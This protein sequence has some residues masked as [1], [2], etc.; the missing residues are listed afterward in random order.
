MSYDHLD[1]PILIIPL[2]RCLHIYIKCLQKLQKEHCNSNKEANAKT[3]DASIPNVTT[4][5]LIL[6]CVDLVKDQVLS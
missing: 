5:D 1:T 4:A 6:V 3:R 2:P